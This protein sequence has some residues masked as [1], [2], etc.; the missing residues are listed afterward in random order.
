M[1]LQ[2]FASAACGVSRDAFFFVLVDCSLLWGRSFLLLSAA[3]SK[4]VKMAGSRQKPGPR[5]IASGFFSASQCH[6]SVYDIIVDGV[7]QLP[8]KGKCHLLG[9]GVVLWEREEGEDRWTYAWS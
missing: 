5:Y 6:V 2:P 3:G 9:L 7:F 8:K 1:F 4:L